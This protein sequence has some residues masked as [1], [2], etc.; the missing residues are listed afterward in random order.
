MSQ[1]NVEI[2]RRAFE[3]VGRSDLEGW[4]ATASPELKVYP[5]REEPG[6]KDC[7]EG[8]DGMLEYVANWYSG[9]EEYTVEPER[10][11]DGGEYVVVDVREIGVAKQSGLRVEENFGHAFKVRDGKIVEWRMF[12]PVREALEAVGL[13]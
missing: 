6:V 10:F 3:A 11:I 9:W 13:S 5:R 8:V 4:F 12:G 2:V 7:Y 1:E